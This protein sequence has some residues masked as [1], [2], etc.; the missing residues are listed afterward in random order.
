MNKI[1]KRSFYILWIPIIG[2]WFLLLTIYINKEFGDL[3]ILPSVI[4]FLSSFLTI[5][6]IQNLISSS[7]YDAIVKNVKTR[8][9][10]I[11]LLISSISILFDFFYFHESKNLVPSI[12]IIFSSIAGFF[13]SGLFEFSNEH[14]EEKYIERSS[15]RNFTIES[16]DR[17]CFY[18]DEIE[19]NFANSVRVQNEITRIR[20]I[21]PYSSFFR[22]Q[23][24]ENILEELKK[25]NNE[26]N[27]IS[28]IKKHVK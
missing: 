11:C 22:N 23:K 12:V 3:K 14:L 24:S 6:N 5:F 1:I 10:L 19:K 15:E 7:E 4:Y 17:W 13:L 28:I 16:R 20:K 9:L 18:L 8:G 27:L 25:I 2:F 26:E 21:L